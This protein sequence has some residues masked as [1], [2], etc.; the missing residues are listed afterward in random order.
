M[1]WCE[2]SA[3]INQPVFLRSFFFQACDDSLQVGEDLLVH[4]GHA[5]LAAALGSRYDLVHLFTVLAVLGQ[6]LNGGEEHRAGKA[7]VRVGA[8]FLHWQAAKAVWQ[9]LRGPAK[10]LFGPRRLG[11]GSV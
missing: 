8:S 11:E 2:L 4:L 6:E 3:R 1:T 5:R 10:P 9:G 7:G